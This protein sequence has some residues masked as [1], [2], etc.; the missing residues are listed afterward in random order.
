MLIQKQMLHNWLSAAGCSASRQ[1]K[2]RIALTQVDSADQYTPMFIHSCS[3]V[4][5]FIIRQHVGNQQHRA[6]DLGVGRRFDYQYMNGAG[7]TLS[8][9]MKRN[10][11]MMARIQTALCHAMQKRKIYFRLRLG[12][13]EA[14][15]CDFAVSVIFHYRRRGGRRTSIDTDDP[16]CAFLGFC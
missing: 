16:T 13:M 4:N 9:F 14:L 1:H 5:Q 12:R 2:V 11:Q 7:Y 10:Q 3:F 8:S 15:I 6:F